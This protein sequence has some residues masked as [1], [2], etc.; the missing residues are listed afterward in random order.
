MAHPSKFWHR[1]F[2]Y[3]MSLKARA[4]VLVNNLDDSAYTVTSSMGEPHYVLLANTYFPTWNIET[5][6]WRVTAISGN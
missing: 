5:G 6:N 4:P 2:F 3:L 1:A